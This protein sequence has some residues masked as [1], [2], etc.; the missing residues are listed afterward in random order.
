MLHISE[1]LPDPGSHNTNQWVELFNDGPL[2]VNLAGWQ[3][4]TTNK[5]LIKLK[6]LIAP[7]E[8]A[9]LRRSEFKFTLRKTDGELALFDP[10]GK[11]ADSAYYHGKA[12]RYQSVNHIGQISFFGKATPGSPNIRE[13]TTFIHDSYPLNTALPGTISLVGLDYGNFFG[14][15]FATALLL[16]GMVVFI[17]T[18]HNDLSELFLGRY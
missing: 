14:M 10:T 9:I 11:L 1:W 16:A 3:L 2:S 13:S 17:I 18:T 5:K 6:G 7:G 12:L 8:Y 15:M 4:R